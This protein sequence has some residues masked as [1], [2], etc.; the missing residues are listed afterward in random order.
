MPFVVA[1]VQQ[2]GGAGKTTLAVNLAAAAHLEGA[3][4][5]LI[6]LDS[7]GSA[8]DWSAARTEGSRLEGLTVI[9]ADRAL[10]LPRFREMSRGYECII[11]DG[12]ARLGNI[13]QSAA[14]ACDVVLMPVQPG[15]FDLWALTETIDAI[16]MADTIREQLRLA[17]VKRLFAITCASRGT[18]LAREAEVELRE[19]GA[20][21]A[22]VVHRRVAFPKTA[23]NGDAVVTTSSSEAA[24][25]I[26]RL[27]RVLKGERT[28][29]GSEHEKAK[30]RAGRKAGGE[31][32]RKA[33]RRRE[34]AGG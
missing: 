12:P 22:G 21:L 7:Q 34:T 15:P 16:N 1:V 14:V 18:Q 33:Q 25:E 6:D 9:K 3:R 28:Q 32:G 10:V 20:V 23:S 27:W 19:A 2:K 8:S 26:R 17:P 11:L 29:D 4:T 13:T 5:L 31:S 30:P 24:E